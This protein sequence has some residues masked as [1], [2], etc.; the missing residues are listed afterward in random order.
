MMLPIV[1]LLLQAPLGSQISSIADGSGG[2]IGV[3]AEVLETHATN[4]VGGRHLASP[5]S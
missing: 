5:S 4:D 1:L 2:H 3:Y